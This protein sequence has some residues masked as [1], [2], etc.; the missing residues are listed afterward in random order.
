MI[1]VISQT[2]YIETNET[3]IDHEKNVHDLNINKI[4]TNQAQVE[5]EEM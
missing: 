2:T 5:D 4:E 3:C 1:N